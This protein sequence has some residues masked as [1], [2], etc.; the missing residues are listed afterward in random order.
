MVQRVTIIG[1]PIG[2]RRL[3]RNPMALAAILGAIYAYL[4]VREVGRLLTGLVLGLNI[5]PVLR[6]RVLPGFDVGPFPAAITSRLEAL[7]LISGPI[8][9]LA[10]GY[11]TLV[12][13]RNVPRPSRLAA[14]LLPGAFCYLALVIDP[15]YY[16]VIPIAHMGGEPERVAALLGAPIVAI[17]AIA[18]VFLVVNLLLVRK[19]LMSFLKEN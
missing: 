1:T 9:A 12:I 11:T 5:R 6:Y 8:L 3:R 15:I 17:E 4:T 19:T 7:G 18:L 13:I 14:R 10:L 16:S 2:G